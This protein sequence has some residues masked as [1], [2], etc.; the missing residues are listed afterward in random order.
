[1]TT[2]SRATL[3]LHD[4]LPI[5]FFSSDSEES[6]DPSADPSPGEEGEE[7]EE[8]SEEE[9]QAS[10]H[11]L[12]DS[13]EAAGVTE[14][15]GDLAPGTVLDEERDRKSTRLNSSHVSISYA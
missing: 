7:E 1:P 10:N 5:Y 8:D 9:E 2:T 13:C 3:S 12:P 4:A 11:G 15:V 6:P 14:V